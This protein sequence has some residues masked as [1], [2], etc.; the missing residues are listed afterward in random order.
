MAKIDYEEICS[1]V[2]E[3]AAEAASFIEKESENFSWDDVELKGMH[4][5]VTG[6]DY[7]AEKMIVDAL[8]P[9]VPG[10]DFLA[11]EATDAADGPIRS[12]GNGYVWII[13]PL[14]GT[15]NYMHRLP[16]YCVSI[17]LAYK[18][19]IVVGVVHEITRNESFYAWQGS[20][21][22]MNGKEIHV[23]Q[24]DILDES[25]IATG[26]SYDSLDRMAEYRL[27]QEYFIKYTHGGRRIGSA[28]A[29]LAYV[30]C[31]R[32]DGYSQFNLSS[33][34]VAAGSLIVR[35]AG[36]RVTDYRGGDD[37]ITGGEIVACN[38]LIYD[39]YLQAVSATVTEREVYPVG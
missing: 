22:Y 27:Q 10:A 33:W 15:T 11:E 1:K 19:E 31:G 2:R 32:F 37:Y 5:M 35:A 8:P 7:E 18:G 9:I 6:V 3:I 30:A 23:S 28:A 38:N 26:F 16:P 29:N 36:G 21:A 34:D 24:I 25:L 4:N 12:K 17:A 20:K 14:D 39:K 13:D